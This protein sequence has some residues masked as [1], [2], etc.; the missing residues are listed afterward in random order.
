MVLANHP[1]AGG[2]VDGI[3]TA[4]G[5]ILR[6]YRPLLSIEV[7]RECPL[8]CPGCYVYVPE[9]LGGEAKLSELAS[10]K[11]QALI[12]GV[13]AAIRRHRPLHVSLVG[14]EPLV[15]YRELNDLLPTMSEM[16]L[17]TQVVTSAVLPI[18]V[19]WASLRRVILVVSVDGLQPEHDRRRSPATYDR[20][21]KHIEGHRVVIHNTVT[22]QQLARDGYF[23]Q[24][25]DFWSAS[26]SVRKIWFSLYTPQIGEDSAE[27]LTDSDR[28]Y[29]GVELQRLRGRYPKLDMPKRLIETLGVPPE[30]PAACVFARTTTCLACDLETRI[31][32]CQFGGSPDCAS[33]GCIAAGAL[34]AVGQHRL[35]GFIRVGG[36]FDASEKIGA[37]IARV[38]NVG[39]RHPAP[40]I[41]R[42]RPMATAGGTARPPSVADVAGRPR[43]GNAERT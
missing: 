40:A 35:F 3:F 17:Y 23:E 39:R 30:S 16:G 5:R 24:F 18:P 29:I 19:E 33:C 28:R 38:R 21:Q 31:T 11:G 43:V 6:G 1:S 8:A 37:A 15:R 4:W 20:I 41:G 36:L 10:L 2:R 22:R 12:D 42:P 7:T 34:S 27:R 14:G 26:P 32:P 9:H 25:L 13:L